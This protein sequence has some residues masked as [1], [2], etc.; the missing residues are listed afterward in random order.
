[1]IVNDRV[2]LA[3]VSGA[4]GVH[5]GQ[6]D[7]PS[8]DAR[9]LL[10]PAAVIGC[11]THTIAQI[12]GAAIDPVSYIAVGPVFGTQTKDT[13][14]FAVGLDLVKEA[15]RRS[16]GRPVVAIG[17]ITLATA[18]EVWAAGASAVAIIGDLLSGGDPGQR[19]ASYN[20][21]APRRLQG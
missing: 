20:R 12:E 1:M 21:L 3:L 19:V 8:A 15:V 14:Y 11:S 6:D 5:V 13:G 4:G 16:R 17:G 10:G 7:F 2:D 18:P 9:G